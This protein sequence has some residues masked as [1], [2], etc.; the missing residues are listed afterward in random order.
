MKL[1]KPIHSAFQIIRNEKS[2]DI[3]LISGTDKILYK[4]TTVNQLEKY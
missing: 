2:I 4:H 3:I 1:K